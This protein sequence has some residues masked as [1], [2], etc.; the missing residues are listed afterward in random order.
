MQQPVYCEQPIYETFLEPLNTI[1]NLAFMV[2]G[3][4]LL[5]ELRRRHILDAKGVYFTTLLIVIGVGS[6]YGISIAQK[7]PC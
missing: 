1:T 5:M 3:V 7:L 4:L 6:F 2:A